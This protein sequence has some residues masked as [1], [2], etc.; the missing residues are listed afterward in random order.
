[1]LAVGYG[2]TGD[3]VAT[4]G[5]DGTARL[6][7][8]ET[9][10]PL[11]TLRAHKGAVLATK[12]DAAGD[13][14]ATLGTDRAVR[15]WDVRSGRELQQLVGVHGRT[16][17]QDAWSEGVAFVG[18]NRIAV[19]PWSRGMPLSPVVARIFD[20]SSGAEVG[21]VKH[22]SAET[23]ARE[24]DVSPDGT[25]LATSHGDSNPG[26]HLYRLP[27]GELLDEVEAHTAG[28]LDIEFSRDDSVIA[29]AGVD[30]A[31][32]VWEIRNEKLRELLALR[33]NPNPVM[34]VSF[35]EDA[36]RLV[37]AGQISQEAR[38]WD[39]SR[40][41][42]GEVLTLPGPQSGPVPPDVAFTPDGR[43]LV[44]SSGPAGTVRVW[45]AETGAELLVIDGHARA[46]A[47]TR[48]VMGVDVSPDGSLIATAGAD[49]SA[50]VYK[51][52]TGEELLAVRGRHCARERGC[53][54]SRAVF[55][56]DGTKIATTGSDATVRIM[57][58]DSGR[59]L[60]VLRGHERVGVGHESRR[61]E[62]R[63]EA[64]AGV[65]PERGAHLGR[66]DRAPARA[67]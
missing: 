67:H 2:P 60:R 4:G 27:G 46:D 13:R 7:N 16:K 63:R 50:R 34:S 51:A 52:E 53:A 6:W 8:A 45:N 66:A 11:H 10:K 59:E 9:G 38:V 64:P 22:P 29:T 26:L 41:G 14:L 17:I 54:V 55:S 19:S 39:V 33:G 25:L 1:M 23:G 62:C 28:V 42:R 32:R 48:G 56:P 58:S 36:T 49:G 47:P 24:I 30:G 12:F 3:V 57:A 5:A 65:R 40:A 15:V 43:R 44:A 37:T 21:V 35:S 61:V 20:L 31:A 18:D